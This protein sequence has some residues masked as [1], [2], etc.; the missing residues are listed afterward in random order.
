MSK[1]V[2]LKNE[3]RDLDW[4]IAINDDNTWPSDKIQIALLADIRAELKRLNAVLHC[5]NFLEVPALLRHIKRNTTKKRK[6]KA[7]GKPKLRVVR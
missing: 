4:T 3:C 5:P 2:S 6:P 7:V 1:K